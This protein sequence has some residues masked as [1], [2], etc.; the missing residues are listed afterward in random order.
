MNLNGVMTLA[1][2]FVLS[3]FFLPT[4][5]YPGDSVSGF[6][7]EAK[8]EIRSALEGW[9]RDFNDKKTDKVCGLFALDLIA[10]YGDYTEKTYES[11]CTQLKLSLTNEDTTLRYAL[12][13]QEIIVSGDLAVVR[14]I[15]I[16]TVRDTS[17]NLIE[18][19]KD[20]GMDI[21]R[22]QADGNW[23]ISRYV[24]YPMGAK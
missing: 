5:S 24:A 11:I 13:I 4:L 9:T 18:T 17:G 15:W 10:N 22:R 2:L 6:T 16:L 20:R 21:F 23:R 7:E 19:T 14:L 1:V 8:R 12:D 3:V